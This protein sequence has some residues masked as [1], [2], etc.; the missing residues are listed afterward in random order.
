MGKPSAPSL[1]AA[2]NTPPPT[3]PNAPDLP[4]MPSGYDP[5]KAAQTAFNFNQYAAEA[6][7]RLNAPNFT[8]AFGG[9]T[10]DP[11]T[12]QMTQTLSPQQQALLNEQVGRSQNAN[13]Y[14]QGAFGALGSAVNKPFSLDN[15]ATEARLMELGRTRLDPILQQQTSQLDTRLRNQGAVPGTPAYDLAMANRSRD[16]NDAYNNLLLTGRGQAVN[17]A[18]QGYTTPIQAQTA[19]LGAYAPFLQNATLPT[20]PANQTPVSVGAPDYSQLLSTL[21]GGQVT[22]RGQDVSALS[23]IFGTQVGGLTSI[24]G[25]QAGQ[26]SNAYNQQVAAAQAQANREAQY[27]QGLYGALGS[28][29]GIGLAGAFGGLGGAG[30]S[31]GSSLLGNLF[32]R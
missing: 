2:P 3:L 23:N 20:A 11:N 13:Q 31:A 30:A 26:Q 24:Y 10:T 5:T 12:G 28:I 32:K 14:V 29:G 4:D 19:A 1:P 17:E 22:G 7:K 8:T 25:T 6:T 21:Y 9:V 15:A 18:I 16:V 27:T